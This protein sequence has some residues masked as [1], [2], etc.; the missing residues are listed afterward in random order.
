VDLP[1]LHDERNWTMVTSGSLGEFDHAVMLEQ[2]SGK[3]EAQLI[4][5]HW[6]GASAAIVEHK[7][8]KRT[9]LLY[10][11]EWDTPEYARRMFAE[12]RKVL[13]GKWKQMRIDTDTAL[14]LT[15]SGDDGDFRVWLAGTRLSSVEGL[16]PAGGAKVN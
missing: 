13:K 11:S 6:R 1:K 10:A 3:V 16:P 12:Y 14:S 2:Y 5:P 9:V 8:D 4:A 15:G 7:G